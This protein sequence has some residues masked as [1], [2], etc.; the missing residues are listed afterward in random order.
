MLVVM[1]SV[2]VMISDD[3]GGGGDGYCDEAPMGGGW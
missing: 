3:V 2:M 1:V